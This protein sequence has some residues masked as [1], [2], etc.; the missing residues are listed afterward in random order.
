MIAMLPNCLILTHR[1]AT[2]VKG[3]SYDSTPLTFNIILFF[4]R[5]LNH[6]LQLFIRIVHSIEFSS[7]ISCASR[8][9]KYDPGIISA[10]EPGSLLMW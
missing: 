2:A 4:I 5:T 10:P 8:K 1:F 9:T 6:I 3:M 7:L